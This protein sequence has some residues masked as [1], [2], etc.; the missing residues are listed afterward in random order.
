M[1]II[2]DSAASL[3]PLKG[4]TVA[5]MGFGAQGRNQ[6]LCL[7]ESGVHV[8]IGVRQGKSFEAAKEDGFEVM[9]VK[10]AAEKADL[11]QILLPDERHGPSHR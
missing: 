4:K 7:R 3:D 1:E 11:I 9:S 8:I 10:E 5:I 6:A 2:H